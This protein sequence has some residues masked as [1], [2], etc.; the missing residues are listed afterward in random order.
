[1]TE[2]CAP[3]IERKYL[4]A[5]PDM[6]WLASNAESSL[7][8]QTYLVSEEGLTAR[9]RKREW[10][11]RCVYYYTEKRHISAVTKMEY[12][13]EIGREEYESLLER[14]D[15]DRKPVVKERWCL[16][17]KDQLFEIDVYPFYTDRAIMEIE[18]ESE[19]QTIFFP[20]EIRILKEVTGDRRYSNAS[21]ARCVPYDEI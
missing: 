5:Y 8:V 15:T 10:A 20:P 18:L 6:A 4:I 19:G 13:K 11:D 21:M 2:K 12:E 9:V 16:E 3:E 1:M 17:Y 14:E 7:I